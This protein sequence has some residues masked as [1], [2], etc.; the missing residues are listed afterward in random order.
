MRDRED[1]LLDLAGVVRP[2]DQDLGTRWMEDDERRAP[3]PVLG[4]IGLGGDGF[5]GE[6]A[7]PVLP[8]PKQRPAPREPAVGEVKAQVVLPAASAALGTEREQSRSQPGRVRE[9]V[10][11]LGLDHELAP[12]CGSA[13]EKRR[14]KA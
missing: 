11:D 7:G 13:G 12:G 9:M 10:F 6:G 3:R 2:A 5:E 14:L 4:G 1:R 8:Q